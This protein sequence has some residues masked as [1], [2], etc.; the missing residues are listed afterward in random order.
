MSHSHL[1]LLALKF[2][3]QSSFGGVQGA[4]PD[5]NGLMAD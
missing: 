1:A 5:L 2:G 3:S 4:A